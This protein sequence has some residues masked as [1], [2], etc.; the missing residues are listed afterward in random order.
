MSRE[1]KFRVW[2]K[3][4]NVYLKN[5]KEPQDD[6]L[7]IEEINR[8]GSGIYEVTNWGDAIIEQFTGLTDENGVEIFKGDIVRFNSNIGEITYESGSFGI[9]FSESIDYELMIKE[10]HECT[11]CDNSLSMCCNDNFI[12][13]WEIYW[14]YNNE[15]NM[16][17]A[18]EVIGN[19]H[20][21]S[22]LLF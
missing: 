7:F 1:I 21:N 3:A 17:Y 2:D 4:S 16:I 19:I 12:S 13:L 22:D 8:K 10:I 15:D 14:N 5:T 9:G 6:N 11:G 20:Q 18:V